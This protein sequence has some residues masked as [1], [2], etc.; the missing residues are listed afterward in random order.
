MVDS[1]IIQSLRARSQKPETRQV[2]TVNA[3]QRAHDRIAR[4]VEQFL[5]KGKRIEK[6][7]SGV[8][9]ENPAPSQ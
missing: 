6:L 8:Q 7:P 5:A 4:E 3:K 9:G 1:T 2:Y